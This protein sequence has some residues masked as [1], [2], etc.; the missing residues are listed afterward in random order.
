MALV[1]CLF[2]RHINALPVISCA[3][4]TGCQPLSDDDTAVRQ[5]SPS[6]SAATSPAVSALDRPYMCQ[7][8]SSTFF[9]FICLKFHM[10]S[11]H[12][13]KPQ[14]VSPKS[15][16][17]NRTYVKMKRDKASRRAA[18]PKSSRCDRVD[19]K[20]KV[21][22]ESCNRTDVKV[23]KGKAS[24]HVCDVCT[25]VL[26][27]AGSLKRHK[28]IHA[29]HCPFVCD[30]CSKAFAV[31]ASLERHKKIH[32]GQKPFV[33]DVCGK[34]FTEVC[35]LKRHKEI[36]A[37]NKPNACRLCGKSFHGRVWLAKH[38]RASACYKPFICEVCS[39]GFMQASSLVAHMRSHTFVCDVCGKAFSQAGDLKSHRTHMGHRP[40]ACSVGIQASLPHGETQKEPRWS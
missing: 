32:N 7:H 2:Q 15:S 4:S 21:S 19:V 27:R 28:R 8:C 29:G 34:A 20:G 10:A 33:C 6:L 35:T 38:E 39:K 25:K 22:K 5:P 40:F 11:C 18:S 14:P 17:C 9:Q 23:K 30:V 37:S 24:Q 12:R 26:T 3:N 36:H 13:G 16:K 31:A 1:F